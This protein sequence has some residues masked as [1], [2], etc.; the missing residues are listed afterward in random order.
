MATTEPIVS[1]T[2]SKHKGERPVT[3][4]FSHW[5][6]STT[7]SPMRV[8]SLAFV[9]YKVPGREKNEHAITSFFYNLL[10]QYGTK[11]Q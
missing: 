9:Q 7:L 1:H 3:S 5:N 11:E 10:L 6:R 8:R 2:P 4:E